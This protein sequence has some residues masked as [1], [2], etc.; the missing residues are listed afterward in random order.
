MVPNV[1]FRPVIADLARFGCVVL[2]VLSGA[3]G[4]ARAQMPP[5]DDEIAFLEARVARDEA[6]PITPTR[7]G[8][9]YLRKARAEGDFTLYPRAEAVFRLALERSP[10]HFGALTG[11]AGALSARH[12]FHDALAVA[13]RAVAAAPDSP[14]GYAAAGDAALEAGLLDRAAAMYRRV[15]ALAAGYHAETRRAN[16]SAA[17]G[18][19]AAAYAALD[20]AVGDATRRG[21]APELVAWCHLRAGAI[22]WDH[23]DW[24][25]AERS[26]AAAR[27]LTPESHVVLEHLAELHAAQGN[28]A[29][30][31]ALYAKALAASP[32]P[33][34][35]EAIGTIHHRRGRAEDAARSFARV[36]AGYEKA[37]RDGD[38]GAYRLLALFFLDV[39]SRPVEALAWARKDAGI[40]QDGVTL[41]VLAWAL[42]KNGSDEEAGAAADKAIQARPVD[43]DTWYR[44]GVVS[45][46]RGDRTAARIRL[47]RALEINP[48]FSAAAEARRHLQTLPPAR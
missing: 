10:E 4:T 8:H 39:E 44:A 42:S 13:E 27:A 5:V 11:L 47:T 31:L 14:D 24:S 45:L 46:K 38:P 21:L 37:A 18:D 17:S 34:F 6:D 30:A 2:C 12:A 3:A 25:R 33:A 23:G 9:A 15:D 16:L 35:H 32:Q 29:E 40:R 7:L 26:Y 48:R 19:P 36:R 41:G 22:A 43:A 28:D 20:R 1:R